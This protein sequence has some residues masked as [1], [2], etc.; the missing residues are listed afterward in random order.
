MEWDPQTHAHEGKVLADR[1]TVEYVGRGHHARDAVWFRATRPVAF[2][3]QNRRQNAAAKQSEYAAQKS[4][5][6][7][8]ND[9]RTN[10]EGECEEKCETEDNGRD[11]ALARLRMFYYETL[12]VSTGEKEDGED[13]DDEEEEDA[14]QRDVRT[15]L[16][17]L[18]ARSSLLTSGS[19]TA[20][21]LTAA[22]SGVSNNSAS[23]HPHPYAGAASST[24]ARGSRRERVRRVV[25]AHLR[26]TEPVLQDFEN[27]ND[28]ERD[29]TDA[30]MEI[31]STDSENNAN[32]DERTRGSRQVAATSSARQ[33]TRASQNDSE[34][35]RSLSSS[36]SSTNGVHFA[37]TLSSR[38]L[39]QIRSR[40]ERRR[41]RHQQEKKRYNHH[42]AV[43][44]A[45]SGA[46]NKNA[47]NGAGVG[48]YH[49]ILTS[50]NSS[51][52][53][54]RYHN[55]VTSP[56]SSQAPLAES[57]PYQE[58]LGKDAFSLAYHGN[59]GCILS[60]N[61]VFLQCEKFG[62]GDV[63]GCGVLLDT[64]TFF[65][66]LNGK[67]LAMLAATDV[68]HFD[69]FVDDM[70]D[71]GDNVEMT[72]DDDSGDDDMDFFSDEDNVDEQEDGSTLFEDVLYPA[73]GLHTSGECVSANFNA[74]EFQF[75]LTAFERQ[76]LKERQ[77]AL[78][79]HESNDERDERANERVISD[80]IQQY[81]FHQGYKNAYDVFK[82]HRYSHHTDRTVMEE[83]EKETE[84]MDIGTPVASVDVGMRPKTPTCGK[85][86]D[87]R[88]AVRQQIYNFR[89]HEAL[90]LLLATLKIGEDAVVAG[91]K[92]QGGHYKL[93]FYL[94]VLCVIDALTQDPS[95]SKDTQSLSHNQKQCHWHVEEAISCAQDLLTRYL[96]SPESS[97]RGKQNG[98]AKVVSK[99]VEEF[100][101]SEVKLMMSLL[102]Y[103]QPDQVPR[104]CHARKFLLPA[105]R[106]H[107]AD[108]LNE[109]LLSS[110]LVPS[111]S[112]RMIQTRARARL[113][114]D[115][116]FGA[117]LQ[118]FLVEL[119]ALEAQCLRHGCRVF[120]GNHTV[121]SRGKRRSK[122]SSR[123][124]RRRRRASASSSSDNGGEDEEDDD[125]HMRS[126]SGSDMLSSSS[127][128]ENDDNDDDD[129]D[130]DDEE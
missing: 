12:V 127:R 91:G 6:T 56:Q 13:G 95:R 1:R 105:F 122:H 8:D 69:D 63:V 35:R 48:L 94:R 43:G 129:D 101:H 50:N 23:Q 51:N 4:I 74:N 99:A 2:G 87:L 7:A 34:T 14:N 96:I 84:A 75:D 59:T 120:P 42:V 121:S 76:I 77:Q 115:P 111:E 53:N 88:H 80:L 19:S 40:H 109:A 112:S 82:Q 24:S 11:D 54:R 81:F 33:T 89:T 119:N 90:G 103:E 65:F 86:L 55:G 32:G 46:R 117:A 71:N 79:L 93:L 47:S 37:F 70:S 3:V 39:Q 123:R 106:E 41:L 29:N 5:K 57:Q 9:N 28:A 26:A 83:E 78:Q 17:L 118:D 128:S 52:H 38:T 31:V 102:L 22:G 73:V 18:L 85:P 125:E 44:F 124:Q 130:D 116:H 113:S 60:N 104:D 16:Q 67:L 10:G 107:V 98:E 61:Q 15:E 27:G 64:K 20:R 36:S 21:A 100:V 66:T 58:E 126:S 72:D 97:K 49:A 108:V 62:A 92:V 68:H 30:A 110:S 45:F 114:P 25:H